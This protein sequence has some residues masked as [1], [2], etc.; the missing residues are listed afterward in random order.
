M[1]P[2]NRRGECFQLICRPCRSALFEHGCLTLISCSS[3]E[4]MASINTGRE[5]KFGRA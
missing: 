4:G 3:T 2:L 1:P 5:S